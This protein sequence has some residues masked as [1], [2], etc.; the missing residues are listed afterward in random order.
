MCDKFYQQIPRFWGNHEKFDL[1]EIFF[2]EFVIKLR[3]ETIS[4]D[5]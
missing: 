3:Q 1:I 4:L 2:S 5:S